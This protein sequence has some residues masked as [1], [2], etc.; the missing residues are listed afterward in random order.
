MPP[1]LSGDV[2]RRRTAHRPRS[3]PRTRSL[4]SHATRSAGC[5]LRAL[6]RTPYFVLVLGDPSMQRA[7]KIR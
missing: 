7:S 3:R 2:S 5:G 4:R 1:L 6:R